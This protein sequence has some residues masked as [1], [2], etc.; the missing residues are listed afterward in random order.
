MPER[1]ST[2][3]GYNA[4]LNNHVLPR[5]G[6]CSIINVQARPVELWLQSLTLAPKSRVAIRGLLGILWD[7][8]M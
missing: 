5:W 6:E 2:R 3:H 4:W 1:I 8:A 7:F